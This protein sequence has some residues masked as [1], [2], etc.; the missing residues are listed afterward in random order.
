LIVKAL[1]AV[2]LGSASLHF[3]ALA[4]A[5]SIASQICPRPAVGSVVADPDEL[6]SNNG[7]LDLELAYRNFKAAMDKNV[8]ATNRRTAARLR[9]CGFNRAT[10]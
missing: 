7:V 3:C 9:R 1:A 5:Q 6:R 10:F 4:H 8:S 2:I